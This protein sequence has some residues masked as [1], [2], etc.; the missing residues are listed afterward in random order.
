MKLIKTVYDHKLL[1]F[2]LIFIKCVS[3]N[4]ANNWT[5]LSNSIS[6][7]KLHPHTTDIF[8]SRYA[9]VYFVHL[10][11]SLIKT[12]N[13]G[14]ISWWKISNIL[15]NAWSLE[16]DVLGCW[17]GVWKEE[18]FCSNFTGIYPINS[19]VNI[20]HLEMKFYKWFEGNKLL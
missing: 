13:L 17:N 1:L 11:Y 4:V 14:E 9:N 12:W 15:G 8:Y 10:K 7:L 20:E 6:V 16:G 2:L 3:L 19:R 18:I 5:G